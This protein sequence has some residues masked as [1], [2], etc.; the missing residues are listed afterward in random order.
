[1]Y[2]YPYYCNLFT[3]WAG[4]SRCKR[5]NLVFLTHSQLNS[6][7]QI[8]FFQI[9]DETPGR[10]HSF[11][12]YSHIWNLPVQSKAISNPSETFFLPS[13]WVSF[14]LRNLC[15]RKIWLALHYFSAL[16]SPPP[17]TMKSPLFQDWAWGLE[18]RERS[19]I[20]QKRFPRTKN[21]CCCS[22][23]KLCPTL[24]IHELP[25]FPVLYYLPQFAQTHVHWIGD[26]IQ[27]S[28]PL[29][30]PSLPSSH[31]PR[32]F[33]LSQQQSLFQWVSSLHQVAKV[34]EL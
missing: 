8:I 2:N 5:G 1:M 24:W 4:L 22:V 33:N 17:L 6:C 10:W 14:A 31:S 19:Y 13:V 7:C 12:D 16:I 30:S 20:E 18:L 21:I 3:K 15:W 11:S 34:L 25:C 32:A 23:A 28:Y 27:P 29:S 26:A 9:L